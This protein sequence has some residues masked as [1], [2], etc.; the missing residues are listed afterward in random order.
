[1]NTIPEAPTSAMRTWQRIIVRRAAEL[2][3][4]YLNHHGPGLMV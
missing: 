2:G 1:M 3:N 4:N